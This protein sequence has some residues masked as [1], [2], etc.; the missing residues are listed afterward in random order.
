V[1]RGTYA[2]LAL[3][4]S[5]VSDP[6][7]G[8]YVLIVSGTFNHYP[9]YYND[10]FA[11]QEFEQEVASIYSTNE[12]EGVQRILRKI[13]VDGGVSSDPVPVPDFDEL[14]DFFLKDIQEDTEIQN[15]TS[16][17]AY[18]ELGQSG[19]FFI[20]Q[21]STGGHTVTWDTDY[22]FLQ[23]YTPDTAASKVN[24]YSYTIITNKII[25]S[26]AGAV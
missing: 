14:N 5:G 24:V 13:L 1:F 4:N 23:A 18:N 9:S 3:A 15:P 19:M 21:D 22:Y 25:M 12:F 2:T 7:A 8:N 10:D 16:L 26:Y 20:E 6:V 17:P 11:K